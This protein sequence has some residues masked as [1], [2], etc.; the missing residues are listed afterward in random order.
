MLMKFMEH[1]AIAVIL[2]RS[3]V[4][5]ALQVAGILSLFCIAFITIIYGEILLIK[6]G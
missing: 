4:V 6:R 5:E 1:F 3:D 2:I